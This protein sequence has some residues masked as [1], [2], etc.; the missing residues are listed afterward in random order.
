MC[1]RFVP[2]GLVMLRGAVL[3]DVTAAG[4][5]MRTV[6]DAEEYLRVLRN[7]FALDVPE[8]RAL[9]PTVWARH[10]EWQAASGAT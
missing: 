9:W 6:Q 2:G 4:V 10:L 3:R 8:M 1:E 5:A 7:R